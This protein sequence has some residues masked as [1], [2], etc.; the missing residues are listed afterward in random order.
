MGRVI[1]DAQEASSEL[2]QRVDRA[3]NVVFFGGAGV[4]TASGIPDFRSPDGLY[5]QQFDYPPETMLSHSFYVSH[6]KEF[7]DF[8]RDRMIAL[9]AKPNQ[10]HIKLAQLEAEGKVSAVV[11]QNIDGLHQ[12]AGS[13][14]VWE[15]HGSVHRNICRSCGAVYS[16]EWVLETTGVPHCEACGGEVKPDVVLYEEGLDERVI[17]GAVR[18]IANADLLIIGGT[19]LV[20][21]PAAGL[22]RYFRG[23]EIVICNLQPT[24]QDSKA[25]LVLACDIAKAFDW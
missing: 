11:T 20:V 9:G 8:Y 21:Y 13:K 10:A 19:S 25:D 14:R 2:R 1:K 15:L 6:T 5:Y 23:D 4:S 17:S 24:S 18:A 3:R 7:F 12:L 22:V 16:A